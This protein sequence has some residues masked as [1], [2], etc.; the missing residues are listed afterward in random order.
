M[1]ESVN[2]YL[3]M[4]HNATDENP[5][6]KQAFLETC[7][8]NINDSCP[9]TGIKSTSPHYPRDEPACINTISTGGTASKSECLLAAM[10]LK[11]FPDLKKDFPDCGGRNECKYP[12]FVED[13][14]VDK[15]C[16]KWDTE[17]I[18]NVLS[19]STLCDN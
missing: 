8:D 4:Y 18:N 9:C 1:P 12:C 13:S 14:D 6:A 5:D 17:C 16:E 11:K 3:A 10:C 2:P 19:N 15:V 7:K